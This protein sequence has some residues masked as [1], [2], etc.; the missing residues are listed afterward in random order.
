MRSGLLR[1][2]SWSRSD[3]RWIA[4]GRVIKRLVLRLS[5]FKAPHRHRP[6]GTISSWL[7]E[8]E[9]ISRL[10]SFPM[11][12]G[13]PSKSS[14]LSLMYK[15][16]SCVSLQMVEG[17]A[18]MLFLERFRISSFC[19]SST[20]ADSSCMP[21]S[22]RLRRCRFG[23]L[24]KHGG[25]FCKAFLD[26]SSS[27]RFERLFEK[28]GKFCN[29]RCVLLM[30][31]TSKLCNEGSCLNHKRKT[32]QYSIQNYI[33]RTYLNWNNSKGLSLRLSVCKF[34]SRRVCGGRVSNLLCDI[35]KYSK[36]VKWIKRV[37]GILSI[38]KNRI[39]QS[40]A[41][42][43][44]MCTYWLWLKFRTRTFL[45]KCRPSGTSFSLLWDKSSVVSSS[46]WNS[47]GG[48]P[49]L[50]IWLFL[51][52]SERKHPSSVSSPNN[53][54]NSLFLSDKCSCRR[55]IVISVTF[56]KISTQFKPTSLSSFPISSGISVRFVLSSLSHCTPVI[57]L[58]AV[59][60]FPSCKEY[61]IN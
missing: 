4:S 13:I 44:W 48:M 22:L 32:I 10:Q 14:L 6:S 58:M 16:R 30:F 45:A 27:A 37:V 12:D 47:S 41:Q 36:S 28:A 31:N 54:S 21:F 18:D 15:R 59:G 60:N 49:E 2:S 26:K 52:L 55:D 33:A 53:F 42:C 24:Y 5:F 57:N 56:I 34:V 20:S 9:K 3:S 35:S 17:S 25:T 50:F 8:A 43:L 19:H 23:I 39:D 51:R 11:P 7:L 61:S 38:L 1:R 40:F 29:V 46:S